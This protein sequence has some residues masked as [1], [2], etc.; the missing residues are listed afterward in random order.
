MP[1]S[2]LNHAGI[3][4][5]KWGVRRYQNKDGSLT[6]LGKKRYGITDGDSNDGKTTSSPTKDSG[7]GIHDDYRRAHSK[8]SVS[9][10]SDKELNDRINRLQREK[11][12]ADLTTTP[13]RVSKGKSAAVNAVKKIGATLLFAYATKAAQGLTETAMKKVADSSPEARNTLETLKWVDKE[14]KN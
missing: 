3:K 7:T 1:N 6:P 10:M 4:G 14:K 12:Y 8:T 13:S 5:M 9:T 2:E 11:Q